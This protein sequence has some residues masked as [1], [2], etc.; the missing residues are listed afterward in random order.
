MSSFL[1]PAE[2]C[3]GE[4]ETTTNVDVL[5][6]DSF[7]SKHHIELIHILKS[8]TQGYDFHVLKGAEALMKENRIGMIYFEFIFSKMY[9]D[10]PSFDEVFRFLLDH[11][12]A[13]V[14]F[15]Q[16]FYQ[17]NLLGWTDMLFINSDFQR[18]GANE[19]RS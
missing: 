14:T 18:R 13:L 10:L 6:L 8:D 4:I 12:F 9:K 19:A 7:A 2:T 3:W 15:Y 17:Q 11:H 5:T 16:P 1:P